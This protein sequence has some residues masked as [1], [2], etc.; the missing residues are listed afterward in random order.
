[1]PLKPR[2]LDSQIQHHRRAP[3]IGGC[4]LAASL[5]GVALGQTTPKLDCSVDDNDLRQIII[6]PG[7]VDQ[8]MLNSA[9]AWTLYSHSVSSK[10]ITRLI[11]TDTDI[12]IE[13]K[14][15]KSP[16]PTVRLILAA[17]LPLDIDSISGIV[18]T[19]KNVIQVTC[20][21]K[22]VV[23]D[24]KSKKSA[25]QFKAATGKTDSDI[26][27]NGSYTATTGGTPTY[28]IDSF[29]G[30]MHAIGPKNDFW[31]KVGFYGQA[32]TKAGSTS[33]SPNSY[34]TYAVFQRV[35]AKQGGWLG[36]FQTPYLSYRVAGGEFNQQGNNTNFI[37]SPIVTFP[38]RLTSGS[39]GAIRPGLT[40]PHMTVFAGTEFVRTLSSALPTAT[41]LTRGVLGST[42]SAGYAPEKSSY[43]S[44]LL[45]TAAYQVRIPSSPEVYYN[46]RYAPIVPATG[47]K[48]TTPPRLG[49]QARSYVDSKITYN[50]TKW[51]GFTCEYTYGS[52]PPAFILNHSTFTLGLTFTVQQTS[53]GRY[54]ILKP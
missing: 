45:F 46:D 30:Y 3:L 40:I 26:Y 43:L 53:Y 13:T 39:L 47:K 36:P 49:T 34:L 6:E 15:L 48:G 7:N 21:V 19:D 2:I 24:D 51:T 37:D 16:N 17:D 27:L 10:T 28:S 18:A 12:V 11:I 9:S 41:W 5:V 32:T 23:A 54:S 20:A 50:F 52:L 31:G 14:G 29:A 22:L 42:F 33:P 35:L 8:S 1:M 44:S 38:F 4:L 25:P